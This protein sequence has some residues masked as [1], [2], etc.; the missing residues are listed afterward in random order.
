MDRAPLG[1]LANS[2][3]STECAILQQTEKSAAELT[4][5]GSLARPQAI[6]NDDA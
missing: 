5:A 4:A 2:K 6:Q 1:A 3:C